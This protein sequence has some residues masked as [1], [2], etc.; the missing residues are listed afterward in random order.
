MTTIREYFLLV[1]FLLALAATCYLHLGKWLTELTRETVA[2]G[3]N[4]NGNTKE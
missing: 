2:R 1:A 3:Y 4:D